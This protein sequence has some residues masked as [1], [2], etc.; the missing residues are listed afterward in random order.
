LIS[1]IK[2]FKHKEITMSQN[3]LNLDFILIPEGE[4][5]MGSDLDRDH[6]ASS[7][8]Q[9]QH[10]LSVSDFYIMRHPITNAQYRP[11]VEAT[12]H[13][14]PLFWEDGEFPADKADHPVVGVNYRDAIAFCKWA[15]EE[16]DLPLRLP[17]EAEWEKAARGS[18]G[19]TYPWGDEWEDGICNTRE[20]KSK[21]TTPVGHNSPQSDSPYGLT[22]LAGN[23]QEWLS[24]LF[25]DYPYDP[26]DGRELLVNNLDHDQLLPRLWDTG[27]TSVPRSLEAGKDKSVIR[28]GSWRETKHQSRCAY[29]S[30]A[31]PLHRSDDTGFRCCYEPKEKE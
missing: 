30:W 12:G 10:T 22:D 5:R 24:N 13:R 15:A 16:T 7:D 14:P 18:D 4:F 6:H 8:E 27:C 21:G 31:A 11:F 26:E 29:R 2:L 23:V 9:P 1:L 19:R 25:G 3:S 20:T 28:G 17:T